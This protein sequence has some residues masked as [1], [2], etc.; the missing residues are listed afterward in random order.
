MS[1]RSEEY[2]YEKLARELRKRCVDNNIIKEDTTS[3]D[4][5]T[6]QKTTKFVGGRLFKNNEFFSYFKK[7][8]ND[9][10]EVCIGNDIEE[11]EISITVLKAIAIP[12]YKFKEIENERVIKLEEFD[13]I[14]SYPY[15]SSM[16]EYFAQAFLMPEELY[17]KA[18]VDNMTK[19]SKFDI[20]EVAKEFGINYMEVLARGEHLKKW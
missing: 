2:Y 13:L 8:E 11:D 15:D 10:F 20:I 18:L 12:F 3:L 4:F 16:L 1:T 5:T 17:D 6:L 7:I 19:E 14:S 9:K